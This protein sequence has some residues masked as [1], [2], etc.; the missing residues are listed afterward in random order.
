MRDF[1]NKALAHHQI[2]LHPEVRE[3][4]VADLERPVKWGLAFQIA[5]EAQTVLDSIYRL[6]HGGGTYQFEAFQKGID[7]SADAFFESLPGQSNEGPSRPEGVPAQK[8][9]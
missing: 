4:T 8:R 5:D 9:S 2:V 3:F 7:A 6:T 1:R